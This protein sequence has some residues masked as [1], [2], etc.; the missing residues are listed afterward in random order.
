MVFRKKSFIALLLG[1]N[2]FACAPEPEPLDDLF[3]KFTPL[4]I[5][6][7][8]A[9]RSSQMALQGSHLY[10]TSQHSN[11]LVA[12]DT[13]NKSTLWKRSVGAGGAN[14][15][16]DEVDQRIFSAWTDEGYV[17]VH[18]YAGTLIQKLTLLQQPTG[19][20]WL[21]SLQHLFVSD[22][23]LQQ[24][25][26]FDRSLNVVD[27]LSVK[28]N[29]RGLAFAPDIERLLVTGFLSD[30][31]SS[32][33]LSVESNKVSIR[34]NFSATQY[35][36]LNFK[37]RLAQNIELYNSQMLIPHTQSNDE[38]LNLVFDS[39]VAP[40]VSV[41][42]LEDLSLDLNRVLAIDTIDRTVNQPNDVRVDPKTAERWIV[43]SGTNDVSVI[44]DEPSNLRGHVEVGKKPVSLHL[45][46]ET[47][48]AYI[49]NSLSYTISEIDM[50]SYTLIEE[51]AYSQANVSDEIQLGMEVF[52]LSVDTRASKDRWVTCAI[53]HPDGKQDGL[54]WQQGLGPRNS[55]TME[56]IKHTGQLHWSGN[57]DEIQDFEHTFRNLMGGTG[58][59]ISPPSELGL[60]S[61]GLSSELDALEAFVFS[62][63][64]AKTLKT[65]FQDLSAVARGKQ[66]FESNDTACSSCHA[67]EHFTKSISGEQLQDDVG[68]RTRTDDLV[69]VG[70]YDTP[71]LK[72]LAFSAPYLHDGSA[73]TLAEVF[74]DSDRHGNT[75]HLSG[76]QMD[77]LLDYLMSL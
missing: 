26:V 39:V 5:S 20:L 27:R 57:R 45:A 4:D 24:V 15:S 8:S 13:V 25:V 32:I 68:T 22:Q 64:F 31:F 7:L 56:G 38:T 59:L 52:F 2:A 55:T 10:F 43:N 69:E 72:G 28:G 1:L 21:A 71:S 44:S 14:V 53:C 66:V 36:A 9:A 12:W 61:R 3:E 74:N 58:F 46:P 42:K 73:K 67:G 60:S 16:V 54:I 65:S 51:H 76:A 37:A 63:P 30:N 23:A 29:P 70:A 18:D 49:L 75:S 17:A 11:E 34:L 50:D 19:V 6:G 48:R 35:H 77:D 40:R 41:F 47:R 33:P 62:M